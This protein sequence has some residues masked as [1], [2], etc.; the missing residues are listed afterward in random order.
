MVHVYLY[1]RSEGK[2]LKVVLIALL[3]VV[4]C[5]DGMGFNLR[6]RTGD[7]QLSDA[8]S[9]AVQQIVLEFTTR[10]AQTRDLAPIIPDLYVKDFSSVI[11][12]RS[13]MSLE[14][15]VR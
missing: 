4:L 11:C 6:P 10:F 14:S 2:K 15:A 7:Q 5:V 13:L 12:S 3:T 1:F 9:Q 8:D